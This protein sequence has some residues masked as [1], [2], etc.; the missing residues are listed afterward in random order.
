MSPRNRLP[1]SGR[2][3]DSFLPEGAYRAYSHAKKLPL[4]GF[5]H[6]ENAPVEHF[7]RE[8]GRQTLGIRAPGK[9]SSGVFSAR[10]GRQTP[11]M[12]SREVRLREGTLSSNLFIVTVQRMICS[13]YLRWPSAFIAQFFSTSA[14]PIH[15]YPVLRVIPYS[16]HSEVI[17]SRPPCTRRTNVSHIWYTVLSFHGIMPSPS[18]FALIIL[19]CISCDCIICALCYYF[20][21]LRRPSDRTYRHARGGRHKAAS[22]GKWVIPP[23][24]LFDISPKYFVCRQ[25]LTVFCRIFIIIWKGG[26][27]YAGG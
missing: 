6:P 3:P 7:Q 19:L 12:L 13:A 18:L 20:K 2:Q 26:F 23:T 21:Q 8:R 1:Q 14:R 10:K 22:T 15:L 17:L 24:F 4:R 9:C 16:W 5:E 27:S 11:G 25:E